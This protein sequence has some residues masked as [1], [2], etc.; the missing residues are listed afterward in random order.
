VTWLRCFIAFAAL[1][2]LFALTLYAGF[3][4]KAPAAHLADDTFLLN[5]SGETPQ[6]AFKTFPFSYSYFGHKKSTPFLF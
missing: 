6:E 4:K 1:G 5:F 2:C 3:F